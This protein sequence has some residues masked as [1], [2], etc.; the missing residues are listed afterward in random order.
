MT[1]HLILCG[2]SSKELKRYLRLSA[3]GCYVSN[4]SFG[5]S[6]L[7]AGVFDDWASFL[8]MPSDPIKLLSEEYGDWMNTS[9]LFCVC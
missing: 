2:S 7:W 8:W 3:T 9:N 5:P 6:G 1:S 4:I